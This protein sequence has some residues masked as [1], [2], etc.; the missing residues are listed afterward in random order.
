[1]AA[2]EKNSEKLLAWEQAK[3]EEPDGCVLNKLGRVHEALHDWDKN[4]LKQLKR[5]LRKAQRKFELLFLAPSL[6]SPRPKQK[7]CLS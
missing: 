4:V 2:R 1:V 5:R 6:M 3:G 7:K